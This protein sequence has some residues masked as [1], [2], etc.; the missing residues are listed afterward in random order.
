MIRFDFPGHLL[1]QLDPYFTFLLQA[2]MRCIPNSYWKNSS[3]KM[4][5]DP[6]HQIPCMV[7]EVIM[8]KRLRI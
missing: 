5:D 4:D 1:E 2:H 7:G 6:I 3:G 8:G